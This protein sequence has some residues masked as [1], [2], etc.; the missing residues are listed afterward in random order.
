MYYNKPPI[1]HVIDREFLASFEVFYYSTT[2]F[3]LEEIEYQELNDLYSS[4]DIV[5]VIKSR[6]ISWTGQ[7]ALMGEKRHAYSVRVLKGGGG[8]K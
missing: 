6:R 4:P 7:L 5:R 8:L 2:Y 1:R 3:R